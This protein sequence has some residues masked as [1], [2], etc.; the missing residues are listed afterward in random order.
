MIG[1]LNSFVYDCPD[2]QA[3][4][5]FYQRLIGGN[6][7]TDGDA[8]V[9]LVSGEGGPRLGFQRSPEYTAPKWPE[10]AGALQAHLDI[11]VAHVEAAHA[12]LLASGAHE[13]QKH[14]DFRVYIDPAGH[15]FCTFS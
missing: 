2:R 3:L 14:E 10:E 4:A 5:E 12:E 7:E 6:I 15:P 1:S 8:W 9:Y 11:Q 13:V